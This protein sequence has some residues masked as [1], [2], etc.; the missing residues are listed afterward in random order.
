MGSLK[1]F[2]RRQYQF[3]IMSEEGA[4]TRSYYVRVSQLVTVGSIVILVVVIVA[5][6]WISTLPKLSN[7]ADLLEENRQL[8]AYRDKV[9]RAL[10]NPGDFGLVSSS[11]LQEL[12]L[13]TGFNIGRESL[14][15]GRSGGIF[16]ENSYINFLENI[17]TFPPVNGFVTRGLKLHELF[18]RSSHTGLDIATAAGEIVRASA[19]GLVVQ[20]GWSE[21]LGYLVVIAH[22]DGYYTV[23]AHNEINF[24]TPREWVTRGQSI[25]KVGVTGLTQGPHL[26][27]EIWKESKSLDPRLFIDMYRRQDVSVETHG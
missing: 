14:L 22:G 11:I 2:W 17:P 1:A 3:L 15:K 23:Y 25:A 6:I 16:L 24:V 20:S 19:S 5:G 13:A 21:D 8:Q 10:L 4:W 12:E 9:A 18:A 26:H 7:Y 27:F